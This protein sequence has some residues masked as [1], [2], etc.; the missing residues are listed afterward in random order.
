[1]KSTFIGCVRWNYFFMFLAIFLTSCTSA[2]DGNRCTGTCDKQFYDIQMKCKVYDENVTKYEIE[3]ESTEDAT[4][5]CR[6]LV[7][8]LL[9]VGR[10]APV[11]LDQMLA[12]KASFFLSPYDCHLS[13]IDY[14]TI[15]RYRACQPMTTTT[16]VDSSSS[17][18]TH[19]FQIS[20]G[21][22]ESKYHS[23]K[24]PNQTYNPNTKTHIDTLQTS[25]PINQLQQDSNSSNKL[26]F[27]RQ[28]QV[29]IVA[30]YMVLKSQTC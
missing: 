17:P 14:S 20:Q 23:S 5:L 25:K 15:Q 30:F 11:C 26:C 4:L 16:P 27:S 7:D 19:T 3:Y 6:V 9:C 8:L 29:M 1:M 28:M 10:V 24:S 18:A 21:T 2:T 13:D 22:Q 12:V